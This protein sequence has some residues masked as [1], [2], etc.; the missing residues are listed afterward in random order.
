MT[1]QLEIERLRIDA[2]DAWAGS[3][4]QFR[5]MLETALREELERALAAGGID[6]H[7]ILR[8]DMPPIFA[9]DVYD[10]RE[11]AGEI[12]RRIVQ[13]IRQKPE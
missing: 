9:G 8:V 10:M 6:E 13:A 5:S 11:T 4:E 1:L 7:Q 2:P 3:A 12:A